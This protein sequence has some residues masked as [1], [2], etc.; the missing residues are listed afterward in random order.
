M[1]HLLLYNYSHCS[2]DTDLFMFLKKKVQAVKLSS[3]WESHFGTEVLT[4]FSAYTVLI[5]HLHSVCITH[6]ACVKLRRAIHCFSCHCCSTV[7]CSRNFFMAC[8]QKRGRRVMRRVMNHLAVSTSLLYTLQQNGPAKSMEILAT[9]FPF[10]M[11]FCFVVINSRLFN[12]Q[13]F[14]AFNRSFCPFLL[15]HHYR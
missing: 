11:W 8:F 9:T 3:C 15:W 10:H 14:D 4:I 5:Q 12:L 6:D 1:S 13:I 2:V 7:D